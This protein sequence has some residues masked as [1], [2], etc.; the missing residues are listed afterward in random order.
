MPDET[1]VNPLEALLSG[2]SLENSEADVPAP[3]ETEST[4]ETLETTEPEVT[5][6]NTTGVAEETT[7]TTHTEEVPD[8]SNQAFAQMRIQNKQY[9][10]ALSSFLTK[11]GVDPTLAKDPAQVQ[12]LLD[13]AQT[14]EQ[15][16]AMNV[17]TELLSRLNQ[18][19]R[20]N[21]QQEQQRLNNLALQGFK[22]VQSKY[23]L[24]D[25]ELSTFA[26]QLQDSGTNP[27]DH[28]MDLDMAYRTHNIDKIIKAESQ[29]AVEEALKRQ[30]NAATHS[31]TPSR[32]NG[33]P[34]TGT[35]GSS[36]INTQAEFNSF[37]RN[38]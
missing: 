32:S 6:G 34:D 9:E 15:A 13:N 21:Q 24:T 23:K 1:N 28:E 20:A 5:E 37:L 35:A 18:L 25:K 11:L 8:K 38:L 4:T 2:L 14:A 29:R 33:K 16:K 36:E 12:Q 27:F 30:K 7:E 10:N 22:E 26:V 31:T 3:A 17:P 19:E